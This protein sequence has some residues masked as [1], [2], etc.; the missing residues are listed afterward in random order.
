MARDAIVHDVDLPS[1]EYDD[2]ETAYMA[3]ETPSFDADD[4]TLGS[5]FVIV[6]E[7]TVSDPDDDDDG[8][9]EEDDVSPLVIRP[10]ATDSRSSSAAAGKVK[11][12][13]KIREHKSYQKL[14]RI[15]K[16]KGEEPP[17]IM[18]PDSG[19]N[20]LQ[21]L[22]LEEQE[23]QKEEWQQELNKVEE[24]IKTLREVL[25]SKVKASQE[26]RRKLGYTVWQEISEDVSQSLRN[27]KESNVYQN[28]E[29]KFT[30]IGK[31]V[32]D[33]PIFNFSLPDS[34]DMR[35]PTRNM[36]LKHCYQKTE[37]VVKTTAEK[38]T[39]IFGGFGSGL[40][41]KLGQIKNS[42][43]FRSFEE[44]VGS[45]LENVKTKVASRS[46]SMQNFDEILEEETRLANEEKRSR[47]EREAATK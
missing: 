20:E 46:N 31:A 2:E 24:E 30:Q 14:A 34:G 16:K 10:P 38:A 15:V 22:S 42:E 29:D 33:A 35:T 17:V 26:L 43:S 8:V 41:T 32:V 45:A 13:D 12:L 39:T 9:G 18:S 47:E 3:T 1:L 5:T 28:V 36:V 27:V 7:D 6:D 37:S 21:G 4:A 44:K 19:I 11:F 23:K 25:G 40:T